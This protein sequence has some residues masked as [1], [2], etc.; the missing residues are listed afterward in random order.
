MSMEI[1][2][3]VAVKILE[4]FPPLFAHALLRKKSP[5]RE[6]GWFNSFQSGQSVDASGRPIPWISYAAIDFLERR[7]P[8]DAEVFEYGAGNGT[9]WWAER[10]A[11][12]DAVEHD[13]QWFEYLR[14]KL[15]SN[16]N[17]VHAPEGSETYLEAAQ[18][19]G[20]QFDIIVIDGRDRVASAASAID[21]LKPDGV[22]IWDDTDRERYADGI[23]DLKDRGFRQ[24]EFR[25]FAPV[26]FVL[27]ETSVFYRD[28]NC[29]GI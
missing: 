20:R 29:L 3:R 23:R 9:L 12:V 7:I 27:H 2:N 19:T 8:G 25:G 24:I 28:G 4:K 26:E 16:A 1:V 15:P 21:S 6:W 10:V 14:K 17:V 11:R 13:K 5:L 18:S 22:L